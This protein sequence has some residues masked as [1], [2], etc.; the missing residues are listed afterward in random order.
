MRGGPSRSVPAWHRGHPVEV[1]LHAATGAQLLV[2]ASRG[3][4]TLAG[5]LLGSVSQH[6]VQHAP[7]AT[8][9][10]RRA[11]NT[12]AETV[13]HDE[14][15]PPIPGPGMAVAL[16]LLVPDPTVHHLPQRRRADLDA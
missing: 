6:C 8:C 12:T 13:G 15:D 7:A 3:H 5:I 9:Q 4:G 10:A 16:H 1:L 14:R 11:P 2:A